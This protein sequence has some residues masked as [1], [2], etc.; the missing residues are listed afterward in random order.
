MVQM[1]LIGIGAGIAAALL[2]VA[3]MSGGTLAFPLFILSGLPI[4]IA[5]LGWGVVAGGIALLSGAILTYAV[6]GTFAGSAIFV[7]V[8]AAPVFWVS[9]LAGLS[10]SGDENGPAEWYPLGRIL[11]HVALAVAIGL[12]AAG[13]VTGYDPAVVAGEATRAL[14]EIMTASQAGVGE[15]VTEQSIQ[16]F[17]SVYVAMLPF[18]LATF[19][20]AVVVF[21]VWL[22]GIVARSSGRLNRPPEPLW[23]AV[24]PVE[25]VLGFAITLVLALVLSGA[26][27]EIASVFAGALG[28]ALALIGLAV[29]HAVTI[30]MSGRGILLSASYVLTFFS[31]LP[32]VA[33]LLLGAVETFFNLRGR[34]M[35][36]TPP[37]RS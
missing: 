21:N 29:I 18:M 23:A 7:L 35:R 27:A 19:M 5:G 13:F 9:R 24:P 36:G 26:P 17:V 34:R 1:V 8:F 15:P 11:M 30:G 14:T 31:G 37:T 33:F 25:I 28:C 32:L 6:L 10:R 16:P 4:A 12:T 22:G 3:P 20:V 2:F